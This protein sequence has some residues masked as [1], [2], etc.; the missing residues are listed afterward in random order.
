MIKKCFVLL[1]RQ[2]FLALK[3]LPFIALSYNTE[4]MLSLSLF[5]DASRQDELQRRAERGFCESIGKIELLL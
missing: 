3:S 2:V 4:L 5:V 1:A